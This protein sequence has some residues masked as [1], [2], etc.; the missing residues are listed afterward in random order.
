MKKL[1]LDISRLI[2]SLMVVAIH[3]YPLSSINGTLDYC[4]TRIICRIAVPIFL[5]IT[6]YYVLNK[7]IDYLKKYTI[8]ILKIYLISIL[9]YNPINI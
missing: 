4:F 9:I 8:K 2:A 7:D 3:T 5:M 1:N 6:G